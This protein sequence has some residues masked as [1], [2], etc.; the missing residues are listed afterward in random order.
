MAH[1]TLAHL[2]E[3]QRQVAAL[4]HLRTEQAKQLRI[5]Q[6]AAERRNRELNTL[7]QIWC[8]GACGT[9]WPESSRVT[10]E[11]ADEAARYFER[12]ATKALNQGCRFDAQSASRLW[13]LM[14]WPRR[15]GWTR[16]LWAFAVVVLRKGWQH[17]RAR[18][19]WLL[20]S[21]WGWR[22]RRSARDRARRT[23]K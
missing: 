11:L 2:E 6:V 4:Q 17:S 7:R 8:T 9:E 1:C 19:R 18:G 3:L 5:M 22:R 21:W 16:A 13:F 12:F 20:F 14:V 15:S 23:T 10:Q